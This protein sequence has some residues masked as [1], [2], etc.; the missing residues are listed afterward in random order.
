MDEDDYGDDFEDYD[1]GDFEVEL[2]AVA[3]SKQ[4]VSTLSGASKKKS[5]H[6]QVFQD[7][8]AIQDAMRNENSCMA[9]RAAKIAATATANDTMAAVKAPNTGHA[10]KGTKSTRGY[11][12]AVAKQAKYA[13]AGPAIPLGSLSSTNHAVRRAQMLRTKLTLVSERYAAFDQPS[14]TEH[15]LYRLMLRSGAPRASEC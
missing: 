7:L 2:Q 13:A 10:S 5:N 14:L 3:P 1:D 15:Q 12:S 9:N 11:K 8:E 4:Q 6:G